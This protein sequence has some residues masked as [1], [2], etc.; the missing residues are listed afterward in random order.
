MT[1]FLWT[2]GAVLI[3]LISW[4]TFWC[5][6]ARNFGSSGY[7]SPET[8]WFAKFCFAGISRLVGFLTVGPITVIGAENVPTN[9]RIIGVGNHQVKADFAVAQRALGRHFR[10]L[11]AAAQFPGFTALLAAW[12]GVIPVTYG[13]KEERAHAEQAC[14]NYLGASNGWRRLSLTTVLILSAVL[15]SAFVYALCLGAGLGALISFLALCAVLSFPGGDRAL[16]VAPQGAL[17]PDNQ[18]NSREFR[19]GAVRIGRCASKITC[20]RVLMVPMGVLYKRDPKDA[21]WTHCFLKRTRS[22]FLGMRNPVHWNPLFKLDLDKLSP[23]ERAH[24]E[25][26]RAGA[27]YAYDHSQVTS[28][29]A[30]VVVG[31]A[32]D[33]NELAANPVEAIEQIRLIIVELLEE[34]AKH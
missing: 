29:G 3:A 1:T 11:G 22:M 31:K 12:V 8:S 25:L 34:A 26:E 18:L 19:A 16:L 14:V 33:P 9:A 7:V 17:M 5:I 15:G 20:E 4:Y 30:V 27:L 24:V 28:Y 32:I 6:Q 13:S 23:E 21:H 2:S 10:S